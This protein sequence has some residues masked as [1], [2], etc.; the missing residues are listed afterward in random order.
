MESRSVRVSVLG[1]A[2]VGKSA[3]TVHFM[4]GPSGVGRWF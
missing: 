2:G 1:T 3:L 4:T